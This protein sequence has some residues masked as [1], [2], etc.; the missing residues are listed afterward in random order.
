MFKLLMY[1]LLKQKKLSLKIIEIT[2]LQYFGR[3]K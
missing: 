2:L 1:F 3:Q